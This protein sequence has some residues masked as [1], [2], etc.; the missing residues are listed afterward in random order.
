MVPSTRSRRASK[1]RICSSPFELHPGDISF[2]AQ[3]ISGDDGSKLS[4]M[5]YRYF[6]EIASAKPYHFDPDEAPKVE[7]VLALLKKP[8]ASSMWF[9]VAKRFFLY[10]GAKEFNTYAGE[11]D[12]ILDYSIAL[13][14]VLMED[15]GFNL[16]ET[17][18]RDFL[19]IAFLAVNGHGAAAQKLL[20]GLYERAVTLEYIRRSPDKAERFVRYGA[21]QEYKVLKV[22]L[23]LVGQEEFDKHMGTQLAVYQTLVG[24]LSL[25]EKNDNLL[26]WAHYARQHTGFVIGLGF[27]IDLRFCSGIQPNPKN[28]LT[29]FG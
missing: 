3:T 27:A 22:A 2:S 11:L 28:G 29:R 4:Q 14:A 9:S 21:I 19:E 13:E 8:A 7:R 25:S 17:C 12:R 20:R 24:V 16:G 5:P 1:V 23:E 10:G 6:A 18:R 26:M 15:I